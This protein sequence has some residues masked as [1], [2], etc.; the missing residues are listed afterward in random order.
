M[1][2]TLTDFVTYTS[3]EF[4]PGPNLNM[5]IGPNGTGKSTLVCA[6]CIGLGWATRHLGRGKDL[7]EFVKHGA[8]RGQIEI[9]LAADPE[10]HDKNPVITT[11][12]KKGDTR[13]AEYF[14]DGKKE[15]KKRIQEL[16]RSFSI[17][18]DNLCQFLPQ[19][20]VV[21]FAGLSPE[22]LLTQTQSAAA[23]DYMSDWHDQLKGWRKEQKARQTEQQEL[24]ETLKKQEDRQKNQQEDVKRLRDR[25]G[26]QDRVTALEKMRVLPEYR[27][28]KEKFLSAKAEKKMAEKEYNQLQR[29]MEP[30]LA[31]V[32]DKKQY[33]DTVKA[34]VD[35]QRRK[36]ERTEAFVTVQKKAIDT[37][38]EK[39]KECD[40][41]LESER[42]S[43][44]TVRQ[45]VPG[46]QRNVTN[47]QKAMETPPAEFD[48][49][50]MNAQVREKNG[51]IRALVNRMDEAQREDE[52]LEQQAKQRRTIIQNAERE[53]ER[54]RSQDGQ[55]M[56]KVHG[57]SRDAAKAWKWIKE[58]RH[59]FQTDVYGPPLVECRVKEERHAPAVE[60]VLG[61]GDALAFTVTSKADFDMLTDQLYQTLGLRQ[62]SIRASLKGLDAFRSPPSVQQYGLQGWVLDLLEGP[63]PVLAMLCDNRN[64]HQAAYTMQEISQTQFDALQRSSIS[65]WVT[66]K[67]SYTIS[68][69][70]EYGDKAASTR[71]LDLRP[72]RF[73][74]QN[75]VDHE[76]E[77]NINRRIA[78]AQSEIDE[79]KESQ[80]AKQVEFQEMQNQKAQLEQEKIDIEKD[81]SAKQSA[82]SQFN[83]LPTKLQHADS[84]LRD[85]REKLAGSSQR[86]REIVQN[87]DAIYLEKGQNAIN[88]ANAVESLRALHLQRLEAEILLIE[89]SSDHQQ[90][91]DQ[92]QE[93]QCLLN[94]KKQQ[95][96][97]LDARA[98]ELLA[99]G[100]RWR[101]ACQEI[102][103]DFC[104]EEH[105]IWEEIS[106]W[107]LDQWQTEVVSVRARLESLM[108]GGNENTL[109][110][111]E[112][113]A[114]DI[115]T[116]TRKFHELASTLDELEAQIT[117][118]REKWEPELDELVGEI[119]EAFA[120]N[121]SKIQ[122]AGEV[123]VHK[124]EDFEN[125]AIQIKVKFR[126]VGTCSRDR[127]TSHTD[128]QPLGK[129][130]RSPSS[131]PTG[132]PAASAPSAPSSTS[133]RCSR[134]R[135]RPSAS[136]TRSTRAWTRATS[137]SCTRAWST[138]RAR[139]PARAAKAA[140][141]FSS[142]RNC[143]R[144]CAI[145]RI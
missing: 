67:Q 42:E 44:K 138:L 61:E 24:A 36:V 46:L 100:Q 103:A 131:T 20:R 43:M 21:E 77:G 136:S 62:V 11:R 128:I 102:S 123:G 19:D 5:V 26:L 31:A 99:E 30:N 79:L 88:Y 2:V 63:E 135:A 22:D 47:I 90:L 39:I 144:G 132:S 52:S 117:D 33:L 6:I 119:S 76:Q 104:P 96:Q 118:V 107:N 133:W 3:A 71:V 134:S 82:M 113:R 66:A 122:C 127:V 140:S 85:A 110:E 75:S 60:S 14:I 7:D 84:K 27:S 65:S 108:G 78:E 111:F 49:A 141:T 10:R 64:I 106:D 48:A 4:S 139:R 91:Q 94:E 51:Q 143:C 1:R 32:N 101:D 55:Q 70:R 130:S 9:E 25:A 37:S 87:C 125:W 126:Y 57:F 29:R 142:R 15:N 73:F 129:T 58:N 72:A 81:K 50:E 116:K 13:N 8:K 45:S 121:F 120:E 41:E 137:A 18:V 105:E 17:Q 16:A 35:A 89:A 56:D 86:K 54:M 23:P 145:T 112:A 34:A 95:Y 114:R 53:K 69:R 59:R 68:R 109:R 115:E 38:A 83:A 74:T 93:E 80:R 98:K 12:I 40:N 28:A 97:Q 92:H 124:D